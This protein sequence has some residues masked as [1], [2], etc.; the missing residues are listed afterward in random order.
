MNK[1][2]STILILLLTLFSITVKSLANEDN[3]K[4]TEI[5]IFISN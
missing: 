3:K 4:E 5:N 2:V 1:I